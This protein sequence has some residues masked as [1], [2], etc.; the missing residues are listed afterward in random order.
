MMLE[1]M[2]SKFWIINGCYVKFF[3]INENKIEHFCFMWL[4]QSI[5]QILHPNL[6]IFS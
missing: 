1:A 4:Y 6:W 3:Q 5:V 2:R